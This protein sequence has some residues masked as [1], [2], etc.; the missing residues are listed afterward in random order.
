MSDSFDWNFP[1]LSRTHFN[2]LANLLSLRS[3]GQVEPAS[4]A[5]EPLEEDRDDDWDVASD[6]TRNAHQLS[7]S[8]HSRLKRKFL[9]C[10]AEF[11]ANRKS[12]KTVACT[13]MKEA[14]DNVTIWIARNEGFPDQENLLFNKLSE[15]LSRLSCSKG[16][17]SLAS[18]SKTERY[19]HSSIQ[20]IK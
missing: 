13:A 20:K 9:D 7:D 15:L 6:D 12:G 14:E 5:D 17:C 1:G 16:M 3:G 8:G 11:A 4:I 18:R 19:L 10:L 2:A